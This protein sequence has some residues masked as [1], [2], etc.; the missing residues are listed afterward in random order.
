MLPRKIIFAGAFTM[1][2]M[3]APVKVTLNALDKHVLSEDE[4]K[5][6]EYVI[7]CPWLSLI[8]ILF[9]KGTTS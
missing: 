3:M 4:K 7:C 5:T 9:V 8:L 6:Q 1:S 2:L